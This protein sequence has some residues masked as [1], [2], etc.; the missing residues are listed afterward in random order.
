MAHLQLVSAKQTIL[1]CKPLPCIPAAE[2]AIQ[3]LI[4]C[5]ESPSSHMSS[6]PEECF[7]TDTG[8]TSHVGSPLPPC[9]VTHSSERRKGGVE[10]EQM[11]AE[12]GRW[13]LTEEQIVR[14]I[15]LCAIY[16]GNVETLWFCPEAQIRSRIL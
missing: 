16:A 11:K 4:W 2:T 7:F 13:L 9:R 1:L 3:L 6:S 14:D 12:R 5:S 15:M 8:V 10:H